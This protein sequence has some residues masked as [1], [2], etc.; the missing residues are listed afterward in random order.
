MLQMAFEREVIVNIRSRLDAFDDYCAFTNGLSPDPYPDEAVTR[1]HVRL[2]S[3]GKIIHFGSFAEIL[4]KD[5]GLR[6]LRELLATFLRLNHVPNATDDMILNAEV[7]MVDLCDWKSTLLSVLYIGGPLSC[8]TGHIQLSG[9]S[10]E[11]GGSTPRTT[12]W[13][14]L[15]ERYDCAIL[16]GHGPSE[17]VFCQICAIFMILIGQEW[18]RLAVVRTYERRRRNPMTGSLGAEG[19]LPGGHIESLLRVFKQFTHTLPS[20]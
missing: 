5:I 15:S 6:D 13:R 8:I 10:G 9:D 14:K 20:R 11:E 3:L 1:S 18:R 19:V 16:Q 17:L 4:G 7:W 2:G 12:S